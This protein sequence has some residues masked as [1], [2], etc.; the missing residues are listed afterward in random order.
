MAGG[1]RVWIIHKLNNEPFNNQELT[2]AFGNGIQVA[3]VNL[4][5]PIRKMPSSTVP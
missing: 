1:K 3:L 2:A 5:P 4:L